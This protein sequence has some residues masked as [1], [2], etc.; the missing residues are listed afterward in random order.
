MN[1]SM[2]LSRPASLRRRNRTLLLI[3]LAVALTSAVMGTLYLRHYGFHS[4]KS[5]Q[6]KFH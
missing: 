1:D 5:S 4:D 3:I 6:V 2:I